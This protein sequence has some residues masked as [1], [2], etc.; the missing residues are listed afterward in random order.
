MDP[1][2][3]V[4]QDEVDRLRRE[5]VR[6][7]ELIDR[8]REQASNNYSEGSSAFQKWILVLCGGIAL[9]GSV[10]MVQIYGKVEGINATLVESIQAGNQRHL[11]TERRLD[12]IEQ[13]IWRNA[14]Q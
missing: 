3:D 11:E 9:A 6:K 7:N 8:L 14:E 1:D 13:K 10:G 4:L 5:N 2:Y 12:R